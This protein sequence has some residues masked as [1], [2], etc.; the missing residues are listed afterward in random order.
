MNYRL[1]RL[2]LDGM[3]ER[4]DKLKE[5]LAIAA[6]RGGL[7]PSACTRA[8]AIVRELRETLDELSRAFDRG[9]LVITRMR[10][11]LSRY[12]ALVTLYCKAI[13][14]TRNDLR[15]HGKPP[16]PLQLL[17]AAMTQWLVSEGLT[18]QEIYQL[19]SVRPS[20]INQQFE[21]GPIVIL[22]NDCALDTRS[23]E[24]SRLPGERGGPSDEGGGSGDL[25]GADHDADSDHTDLGAAHPGEERAG[26]ESRGDSGARERGAG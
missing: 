2:P 14:K 18:N 20:N 26:P 19:I 6:G 25:Q 11:E 9:R 21:E 23:L 24:G 3:A 15:R 10:P 8:E 12:E 7:S 4:L 16:R 5:G 1:P 17:R 22:G 13:G